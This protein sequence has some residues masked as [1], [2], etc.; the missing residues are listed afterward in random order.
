MTQQLDPHLK[1]IFDEIVSHTPELGPTP[2]D[3]DDL[4]ANSAGRRSGWLTIAAA[5][6]MVAGVGAVALATTRSP[7]D[8]PAQ[9]PSVTPSSSASPTTPSTPDAEASEF[10]EPTLFPVLEAVPDGLSATAIAQS[11]PGETLWTEALIGRAVDGVLTDTVAITV[12]DQPFDINPMDGAPA[13]D[14][15][16][17]GGPAMV[18]EYGSNNGTSV[19]HVTWGSGPYFLAS[20]AQPLAFLDNAT[21]DTFGVTQQSDPTQPPLLTF[22]QLPDSYAIVAAP[23]L[24][25]HPSLSASLSIGADNY[26]ISVGTRNPLVTMSLVGPLRS[27][28]VTGQPG[29]TFM[30]SLPTQDITWQVNESTF[31]YLKINDGT[32]ATDAAAL[33]DTITFVDWNTWVERYDPAITGGPTAPPTD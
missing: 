27:T 12:Q 6:I 18:Y 3:A 7:V 25:G 19:T 28:D 1:A 8:T 17:F 21:A 5:T 22:G 16:V 9:A 26:D 33:A 32:S 11:T 10:P 15:D 13:T 20:G 31:A 24:V 29:W 14:A 2:T 23:R 4:H 30:S